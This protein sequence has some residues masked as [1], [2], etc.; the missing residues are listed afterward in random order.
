MIRADAK[1]TIR[2]IPLASLQI[3]GEYEEPLS[4]ER[5]MFYY[6]KLIEHPEM[7]AGLLFTVPSDSHSGMFCVLDGRH[8]Y[9]ASI[10]AGR[11]DT[12]CVVNEEAQS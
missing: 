12:P 1:L 5:V 10:L 6:H 11:K 2:R 4:P 3:K 7:D 8:R 9:L